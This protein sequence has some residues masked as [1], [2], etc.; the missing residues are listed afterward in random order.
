MFKISEYREEVEAAMKLG[1]PSLD[2]LRIF[3]KVVEE[4]SFGAAARQMNRA[5]SAISYGI[6]QLEAQLGVSLFER[7]GSRKPVLT[8][9]GEGLLADARRVADGVDSLLAKTRSLHAGLESTVS[10]V[11]DVMVPGEVTAQ[12]LAAFRKHYPT[13]A[14]NLRVEGLGAVAQCLLDEGAQVAIGGPTIGDAPQLERQTIGEVELVPVAAPNH[15]LAVNSIA[16]GES[17]KHLQL[18]LSDRSTRT[19]GREFSVLS[20]L[21]WRLGDLG[22]KHSLLKQGLGWGN[23]PLEMVMADLRE[24]RLVKLDLPEKPG[25]QYPLFALWRRDT[26]LGP[27]SSWLIGAFKDAFESGEGI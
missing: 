16:P 12:V 9:A 22:A 11:I 10:L 8:K 15:P 2:Q 4:G 7:E 24:G 19:K 20:Q 17:R 27:A 3:L 18:V 6:A 13:V 1:E 25:D 23:M 14:L 26:M 5:V 21:T